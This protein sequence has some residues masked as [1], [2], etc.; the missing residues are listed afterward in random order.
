RHSFESALAALP[1]GWRGHAERAGLSELHGW[2]SEREALTQ[3]GAEQKAHDLQKTRAGLES[4][5][6]SKADLDREIEAFPEA[7]RRPVAEVRELFRAARERSAG[8]EES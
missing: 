3:G 2:K 7:A 6:H 1:G 8:C 4:L 5:A